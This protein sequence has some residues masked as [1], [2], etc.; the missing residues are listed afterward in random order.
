[1]SALSDALAK[2]GE[3]VEQ[4]FSDY[5]KL[6]NQIAQYPVLIS[7]FDDLYM[8]DAS[9]IDFTYHYLNSIMDWVHS[10]ETT[11]YHFRFFTAND[12]TFQ[13]E[14]IYY[15]RSVRDEA[16]F[17]RASE[18]T[19]SNPYWENAHK[20]RILEYDKNQNPA[21]RGQEISLFL[22]MLSNTTDGNNTLLEIY[23]TPDAIF[24]GLAKIEA[25]KQGAVF[26]YDSAGQLV[27]EYNHLPEVDLSQLT[28][29]LNQAESNSSQQVMKLGG[30]SF[31]TEVQ[32]L[33]N[34]GYRIVGI[35]PQSLVIQET[36]KARNTFI[37]CIVAALVLMI[38]ISYVISKKLMKKIKKLVKVMKTVQEGNL[39]TQ[40][41][42]EGN[43]EIAELGKDFNIMLTR[44]N[45]LIAT[46]YKTEILQKDALLKA[47][48]NQVN[49]HFLYNTLETIKMMA[50]INRERE[51][52][53]A[54][55]SL[56]SMVR[57]NLTKDN[58]LVLIT[59]EVEQIRSYCNLQNLMMNGRLELICTMEEWIYSL[60]MLKLILQP[61]VE[62]AI[63]HG[64]R[65]FDGQCIIRIS[66]EADQDHIRF[67]ICDNGNG[68]ER[69]KLVA[70]KERLTSNTENPMHQSENG[71]GL[72]NVN[73]RLKLKYGSG[74]GIEVDSEA[75]AGTRV[76]I[77][78]PL[79]D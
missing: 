11:E 79:I 45:E 48:E 13:N 25:F 24:G 16:W 69:G 28:F 22:P 31:L 56:G 23:I 70:L 20:A 57:Y 61:I 33:E 54:L 65:N 68:M 72:S 7:Y 52:S 71:I 4:I 43:D 34:P 73:D 53:D 37:V 49:P 6:G 1:M 39:D 18:A 62:N 74:Y 12:N 3:N 75:G 41:V 38:L 44:I 50:E 5:R 2:E 63:L 9:K 78:L 29:R 59:E 66:A 32:M 46:V 26:V 8:S 36:V 19:Y 15:A 64:F 14:W 58:R 10:L 55:T 60:K 42:I 27:Y 30:Q 67:T 76:D 40:V 47:L 51:I 35:L 21:I 77:W 17:K